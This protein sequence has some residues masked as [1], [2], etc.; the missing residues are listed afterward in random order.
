MAPIHYSKS[1]DAADTV[2]GEAV[3][4]S[5]E[6]KIRAELEDIYG[7]IDRI[8]KRIDTE[9]AGKAA[10]DD[11]ETPPDVDPSAPPS[12]SPESPSE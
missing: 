7:K 10:P 1:W 2:Q 12:P 6:K 11:T 3:A 8:I 5:E 4:D 9:D